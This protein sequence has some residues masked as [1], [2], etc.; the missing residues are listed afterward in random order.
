[1]AALKSLSLVA[2]PKGAHD[3][4]I[5]RRNKLIA[6]L[7]DQQ[8]VLVDPNHVRTVQRWTGKDGER[9]LATIQQRVAPWW[10]TDAAGRLL[11]VVKYGNKPLEFEKGKSAIAVPSRDQLPKVIE[12]LIAAVQVGELDDALARESKAQPGSKGK[13]AA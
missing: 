1:M 9:A 13:R 2:L 6:R 11:M 5:A 8:K 3:P 4:V 7:E 12:T 10:R